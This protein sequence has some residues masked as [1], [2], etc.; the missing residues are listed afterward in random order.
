[1]CGALSGFEGLGFRGTRFSGWVR[2]RV[3][4]ALSGF[5]VCTA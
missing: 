5:E 2:V 3:C 4:G 1:M